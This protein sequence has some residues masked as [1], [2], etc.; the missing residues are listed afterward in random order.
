MNGKYYSFLQ[1]LKK[2]LRPNDKVNRSIVINLFFNL[3]YFFVWIIT[4]QYRSIV[5][6]SLK[7]KIFTKF[8]DNDIL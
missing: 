7:V 2:K 5:Y 4:I 8:Y 6:D 3:L 1:R